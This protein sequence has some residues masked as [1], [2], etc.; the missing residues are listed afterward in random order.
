MK[1]LRIARVPVRNEPFEG[2]TSRKEQ[3]GDSQELDL[4][5]Q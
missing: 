2:D 4:A 3:I 5:I 1:S